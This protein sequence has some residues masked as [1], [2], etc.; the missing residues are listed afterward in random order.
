MVMNGT[1]A[2]LAAFDGFDCSSP[3]P[4]LAAATELRGA[5]RNHVTTGESQVRCLIA[6]PDTG[7]TDGASLLEVSYSGT[8]ATWQIRYSTGGSLTIRAFDEGGTSLLTNGPSA[9][10]MDGTSRWISLE[11]TQNGADIDW[12]VKVLDPG[13]TVGGF[14]SG[15][16]AAQTFGRPTRVTGSPGGG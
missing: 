2:D 8:A 13:A 4:T 15:T 6:I 11:L 1:A 12:A 5:V 16:V 10:A 14:V 7:T 3:I 9:F